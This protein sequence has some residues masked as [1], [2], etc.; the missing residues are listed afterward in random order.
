MP[1]I[2]LAA[3]YARQGRLDDAEWEIEQLGMVR[4][5]LS[6]KVLRHMLPQKPEILQELLSNLKLAGMPE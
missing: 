3:T 4:E 6:I 1:R 5:G 2:F